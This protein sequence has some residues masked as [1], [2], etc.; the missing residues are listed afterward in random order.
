MHACALL[1]GVYVDCV[2][3]QIQPWTKSN[4][5]D[6]KR[7][8][9]QLLVFITP[10]TN[11]CDNLSGFSDKLTQSTLKPFLF[12]AFA[13]SRRSR[14][15]CEREKIQQSVP[16]TK[17]RRSRW[18]KT[19]T[20][21]LSIW[22]PIL[23]CST[24]EIWSESCR[25]SKI[26]TPKNHPQVSVSGS[27]LRGALSLTIPEW[28]TR[29]GMFSDVQFCHRQHW[30]HRRKVMSKEVFGIRERGDSAIWLRHSAR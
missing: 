6:K 21:L 16:E 24:V 7:K 8:K 2:I 14:I 3:F 18:W 5:L 17:P 25:R 19:E 30:W 9:M 1:A 20:S 11:F 13:A 26:S 23:R 29:G 27:T 12:F 28:R 10:R 4:T 22:L 15:C